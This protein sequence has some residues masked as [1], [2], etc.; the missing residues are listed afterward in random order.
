MYSDIGESVLSAENTSKAYEL[1][2]RAS[3]RERFF[4]TST[5]TGR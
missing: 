3:D 5:Y 2:D 4:I 1:R